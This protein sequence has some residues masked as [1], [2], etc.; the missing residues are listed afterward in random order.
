LIERGAHGGIGSSP[1]E[2]VSGVGRVMVSPGLASR[3]NDAAARFPVRLILHGVFDCRLD[4]VEAITTPGL[5]A[6]SLSEGGSQISEKP[7]Q[8]HLGFHA[9]SPHG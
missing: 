7:V 6:L 1:D 9:V 8:V 3:L 2:P 5:S 4:G